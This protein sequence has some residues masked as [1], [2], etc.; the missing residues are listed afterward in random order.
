ML[1]K[2]QTQAKMKT[3]N[4]LLLFSFFTSFAH[5]N[6]QFR[7]KYGNVNLTSSTS[8]YTEEVNTNII[9]AKYLDLLL[10]EI[11]FDKQIH[12][13]LIHGNE[14]KCYAYIEKE[15]PSNKG[16]NI[17]IFNTETDIYKTLNLIYAIIT[18][19]NSTDKNQNNFQHW[20]NLET[21]G[22][23]TKILLNKINRPTDVEK[24][25]SSKF[26]DYYYQ[27]GIYFILTYQNREVIEVA[28]LTKIVQFSVPI[29]SHLC[30]FLDKYSLTIIKGEH[31]YNFDEKKYYPTF[32]RNNFKVSPE[33]QY[34]FRPYSIRPLGKKYISIVEYFGV[35]VSVFK[36]SESELIQNIDTLIE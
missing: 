14:F 23:L 29:P 4:L 12:L 26:F 3:I 5:T 24:I 28:Q 10:S 34:S 13:S 15:D 20:Y 18:K 11:K 2:T 27:S 33:W 19:S 8:Y 31:K 36:I 32:E 1:N 16:L 22:L 25:E 21:P 9:T 7:K 17:L 6:V 30:I 35:K